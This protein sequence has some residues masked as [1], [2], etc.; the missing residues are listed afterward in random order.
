M[1][2]AYLAQLHR[3]PIQTKACTSCATFSLTDCIA[4]WRERR[5]DQLVSHDIL[6]TAQKGAFGLL[7]LGPLNHVFWGTSKFGLEYWL[8]GPS[9][10]AVMMRVAVDQMTVMPLNMV[11][12]LSWP[13]LLHG[14]FYAARDSIKHSF[15]PS[16][17]FA[18][19]IWPLVHPLSFRYVPLEHRL[20]VLN[21]CSIG[22][23]SYATWVNERAEADTT[24]TARLDGQRLQRIKTSSSAV[25]AGS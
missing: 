22:V 4:Q 10:R 23:F 15:W 21:V 19:S 8:P 2:K 12:F 7:W 18:L 25:A 1:W 24:A 5:K 17:T 6:R 14:D 13:Y 11:V 3:R 16:F 9:W 20:L